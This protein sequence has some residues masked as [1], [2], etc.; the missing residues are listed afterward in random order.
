MKEIRPCKKCGRPAEKRI[1]PQGTFY[2]ICD[3]CASVASRVQ[4]YRR[5]STDELLDRKEKIVDSHDAGLRAI[6]EVLR[7]RTPL[8]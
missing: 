7:R 6:E 2:W 1:R 8:A 4:E 3:F 5:L